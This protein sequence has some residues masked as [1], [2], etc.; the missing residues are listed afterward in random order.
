[1]KK[2][3][4]SL[5]TTFTLL[6]SV[7]TTGNAQINNKAGTETNHS[8]DTPISVPNLP[9]TTG[10]Y[11]VGTTN[12][13][14]V[15]PSRKDLITSDPYDKRELMVQLWYPIDNEKGKKLENYIP[16][17]EKG[18]EQMITK[19]NKHLGKQFLEINKINTH[20]YKDGILSNKEAKYPIVLF[21]HGNQQTRWNYQTITRELASHGFIVASIEHSHYALGTEFNG[22]KFISNDYGPTIIDYK[23]DDLDVNQLWVKD[24]QF[25]ISKLETLNKT[26]KKLNFKNKLDLDK[27]AAIGHSLGGAAAAR[28]LQV[29]P[30]IKSAMDI[31]GSL[32]GLS[33]KTAKMKKPFAFIKTEDHIKLLKG[34]LPP[35]TP[36]YYRKPLKKILKLYSTRYKQA[37]SGPAYDITIMGA[38]HMNFSDTPLLQQYLTGSVFADPHLAETEVTNIYKLNNMVILSFLEKT[39]NKKKNTILNC[40]NLQIPDLVIK[41]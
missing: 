10:S 32:T 39:L 31:D 25:V 34:E 35:A 15:D 29:E 1:M 20:S 21:S 18:I 36:E 3:V 37:V 24:I 38:S 23:K 40:K 14:W 19:T 17:T 27:I 41:Q 12:F 22:G 8:I 4:F 16:S 6:T 5:L 33:G 2:A 13:D 28:A 30:K 9:K 7:C 11:K 26:D